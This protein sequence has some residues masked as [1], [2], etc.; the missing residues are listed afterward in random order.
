MRIVI[1]YFSGTGNTARIA[2]LMQS[3]FC[4]KD[5]ECEIIPIESI[6][7]NEEPLRMQGYDLVGIGYPVHAMDAPQIVYDFID[8]LPKARQAYFMFKTAGSTLLYGG[9]SYKLKAKLANLGWRLRHEELYKMPPNMFRFPSKKKLERL[10]HDV[11]QQIPNV[12]GQI[13]NGEKKVLPDSELQRV[14]YKF[15]DLEKHGCKQSSDRWF[16]SQDCISCGLCAKQCPTH[17]IRLVENKLVFGQTCI[18]CLRCWWHCPTR[19]LK[20]SRMNPF[21]LKKPYIL[22][23]K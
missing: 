5:Q 21:F 22:P 23:E 12:V 18:L 4:G 3:E 10:Y 16:V 20:H 14:A 6:T 13:L 15:A 17:N 11:T 1:Y 8:L 2:E 9:S 7:L 19:A